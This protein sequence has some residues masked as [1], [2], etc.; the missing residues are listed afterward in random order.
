M[1]TGYTINFG[2]TGI[3][4]L[5][6]KGQQG[7]VDNKFKERFSNAVLRSTFNI[8]LASTLDIIVKP[9]ENS[10]APATQSAAPEL[11][12]TTSFSTQQGLDPTQKFTQICAN[13]PTAISDKTSTLYTSIK[14]ACDTIPVQQAS[15]THDQRFT[16]LVSAITTAYT[17]SFLDTSTAS[18]TP[19]Q[20]QT[21][22]TQAF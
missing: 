12:S 18:T 10:H 2:G 15:A 21:A 1:S 9:V 8:A 4:N 22:S 17:T 3:D 14:T 6:R 11:S 13:V 16:A 20:A 19:S 7:R 5:G